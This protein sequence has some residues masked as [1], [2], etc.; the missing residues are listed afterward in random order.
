MTRGRFD[1][2]VREI[3]AAQD[4][5]PVMPLFFAWGTGLLAAMGRPDDA[6]ED[7]ARVVEIAPD[8]GLAYFHAGMAYIQKGFLDQAIETFARSRESGIS[9]GWA[10]GLIG[11]C[12]EAKGDRALAL[13]S[14]GEV[15]S[16]IERKDRGAL[17][18]ASFGLL[19]GRL[20]LL[21]EAFEFLDRAYA[22]R[23]PVMPS[24]HLYADFLAPSLRSD[25]RFRGLLVRMK[26]PG[27]ATMG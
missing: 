1:E 16:M 3:R 25:P 20:G 27:Y 5:D 4:L 11:L 7:F 26:A 18:F 22:E 13:R 14:F 19:A 12:H 2:S 21:D 6:L 9:A 23:D 8:F 10:E 24:I 15:M 17:S